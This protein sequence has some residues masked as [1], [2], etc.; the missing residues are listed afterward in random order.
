MSKIA[1][2]YP[3]Q[4]AQKIGMGKDFYESFPTAKAIFDKADEI[5]DICVTDLCFRENA[6]LDQTAY[7]Q[8]ALVTTEL[9]ITAVL[10]EK[11]YYPDLTAGLS[12]GEYSAIAAAGG[13]SF[14]TAIRTVRQRGIFMDEATETGQGA[15]AAIIGMET[16]KIE[17]I[18]QNIPN[19]YIANYNCPGQIVITGEAKSVDRACAWLKKEGA[20]RTVLL[21]VSG[22]FHSPYL[23]NAGKR[24]D[25]FL[26]NEA[27]F[28]LRIPY[29]SNVTAKIVE[30]IEQT[31]PLLV[32]QVASSVKWQQS[33]EEM[34][35]A[36]VDTFV[37]IGPGKTLAAFLKKIKKD[38]KVININQVDCIGELECQIE[39]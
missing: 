2:L 28:K 36:G 11:G 33:M 31:K 4:G 20:K 22:P 26:R 32:K 8:A 17:H 7:T 39:K 24:L 3:G 37:E 13:C 5:L 21:H 18:L 9:A 10:N 38:V 35:R 34:I 23:E 30:D 6:L 1:F 29:V 27:F 19:T 14:E 16:E 12:L 15:M 25:E